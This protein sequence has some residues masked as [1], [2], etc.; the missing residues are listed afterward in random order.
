MEN[1]DNI[2]DI[3]NEIVSAVDHDCS[4]GYS[5]KDSVKYFTD[6]LVGNYDITIDEEKKIKK[7]VYNCFKKELE[8]ELELWKAT[9]EKK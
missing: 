3:L 2:E 8:E 7:T 5:Y 9:I 4:M 1:K 6:D